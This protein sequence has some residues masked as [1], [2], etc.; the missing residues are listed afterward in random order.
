MRLENAIYG[1]EMSAHHYFETFF[2]DGGMILVLILE[3]ISKSGLSLSDLVNEMMIKY[4]S[5]GG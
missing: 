1:G 2:T 4:P 3:L 5:P